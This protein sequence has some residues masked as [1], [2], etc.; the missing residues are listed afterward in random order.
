M[1]LQI[2]RSGRI[3]GID[4]ANGF[5]I[6]CILQ[7]SFPLLVPLFFA[8]RQVERGHVTNAH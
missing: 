2:R 6:Y 1:I 3:F 4:I 5:T 7:Q 8:A